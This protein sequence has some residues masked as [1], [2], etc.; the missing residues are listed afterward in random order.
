VP[1]PLEAR[2]QC[3]RRPLLAV[4]GRTEKG[5]GFVHIKAWRGQRLLTEAIITSGI[6]SVKCR[7]C[8]R[9][10]RIK[11]TYGTGE[12]QQQ[13]ADPE[14]EILQVLEARTSSR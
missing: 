5:L 2:C 13:E 6:V 4:C 10:T 1:E 11:I 14:K 12:P 3:A 7:E 9:W 8:F